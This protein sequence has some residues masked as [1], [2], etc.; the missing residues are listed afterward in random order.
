MKFNSLLTRILFWSLVSGLGIALFWTIFVLLFGFVPTIDDLT[1]R[2]VAGMSELP[3][4]FSCWWS[5]VIGPFVTANYFVFMYM[6]KR[7]EEDADAD[8][9]IE[10]IGVTFL[11][12][13]FLGF[14]ALFGSNNIAFGLLI[15]L[16][17][18][19]FFNFAWSVISLLQRAGD[20][21]RSRCCHGANNA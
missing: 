4:N 2:P 11:F 3:I 6:N 1:M 17:V 12:S 16:T 14:L 21:I 5:I 20:Y 9:Y 8:K 13:L 10:L 18:V 7:T 19:A 15:W